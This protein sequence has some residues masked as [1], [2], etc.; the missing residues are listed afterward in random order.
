MR[1]YHTK[2]A[3]SEYLDKKK[4]TLGFV[5]TMGALHTGHLSLVKRAVAENPL[6][7]V[8][9]FVNPTQFNKTADLHNY[10]RTLEEDLKRLSNHADSIVVF[11]PPLEELYGST[12]QTHSYDFG[13]LGQFMEGASRGNHFQGV[14]TVVEKLFS[15]VAPQKAYFGEKDYQQL[16]I[17]R[18]LTLKNNWPITVVGCPIIREPNGL[19]MSSRNVFLTEE[20]KN[21]AKLLYKTLQ[22]TAKQIGKIPLAQIREKVYKDFQNHPAFQLDYFC[23]ADTQTLVPVQKMSAGKKYRAFIAAYLKQIRLIDNMPITKI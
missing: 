7:V 13:T 5:P 1:L 19:A 4:A 16:Q 14:A 8:S 10:P 11:A 23:I 20:D 6:T 22:W 12:M 15:L 18:A 3:L 17:I 2:K 21:D 9:I